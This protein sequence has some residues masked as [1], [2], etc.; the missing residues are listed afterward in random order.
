[1]NA[2]ESELV[3]P[4]TAKK[5]TITS[6][7]EEEIWVIIF[8]KNIQERI[9]QLLDWYLE[10]S[11]DLISPSVLGEVLFASSYRE[12][13][14]KIA[15]WIKHFLQLARI[16]LNEYYIVIDRVSLSIIKRL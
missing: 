3:Y 12:S 16:N 7:K 4:D 8:Y 15:E 6:F 9:K 5:Y 2:Q 14:K 1:M 10:L 13:W 11:F